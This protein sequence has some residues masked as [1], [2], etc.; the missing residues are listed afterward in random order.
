MSCVTLWQSTDEENLMEISVC[1]TKLRVGFRKNAP[2]TVLMASYRMTW[3][4]RLLRISF[5]ASSWR[6]RSGIALGEVRDGR[7][8]AVDLVGAVA[9]SKFSQ[10]ECCIAEWT[11][12]EPNR[13]L[14]RMTLPTEINWAVAHPHPNFIVLPILGLWFSSPQSLSHIRP[15]VWYFFHQPQLLSVPSSL[16]TAHVSL[17]SRIREGFAHL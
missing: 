16:Y 2:L 10:I 11:P 3:E 1:S 14:Q 9:E 7:C 17:L 13:N 15:L 5:I 6:L 4:R 12:F 8:A